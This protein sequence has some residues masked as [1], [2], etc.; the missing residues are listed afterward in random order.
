MLKN[1]SP[2]PRTTF[3]KW[4]LFAGLTLLAAAMYWGFSN[5]SIPLSKG[6]F[7]SYLTPSIHN[8]LLPTTITVPWDKKQE[9]FKTYL[10]DYTIDLEAQ[11]IATKLLKA[12]RSDYGALV[13]IDA[14]T[15]KILT[16]VSHYGPDATHTQYGNLALKALF[17]SASVFKVITAAAAIETQSLTPDSVI[18]FN[19][20]SHTLY[21]KNV[22]KTD[23]NRWTR[24]MT[25]K[26]AFGKSVNTVFGKLG[27]LYIGP[28][29]LQ[30]YAEKFQFNRE[31]ASDFDFESG[32][33]SIDQ[34]D[35][36]QNAEI[37]SGFTSESTLSPLHGAL[38]AATIVNDG[39]MMEPFL[40]SEIRDQ[41]SAE[42]VFQGNAKPLEQS[43][44]LSSATDLQSLMKETVQKG[45]SRKS[46]Q[47]VFN[48]RLPEK[49]EFGGKTGT[50]DNRNEP[51]G[52]AD[53]FVG[54]ADTGE[55][56]IAIAVL[57]LHEKYWRVKSS[58]LAGEFFKKVFGIEKIGKSSAQQKNLQ[59][60]IVNVEA[61]TKNSSTPLR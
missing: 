45:T 17:P 21:K 46:F 13:A 19:G 10:V 43:L 11:E 44:T 28:K 51:R 26:E 56:K 30:E 61:A 59:K 41:E 57:T 48:R 47:K 55:E 18:P 54:Y 31:I 52:R 20:A 25:L 50:L 4:S 49:I 2:K 22:K 38:I 3:K 12:N 27:A 23:Y 14:K 35:T 33:T 6:Y 37:A 36:Y 39:L 40:I 15:G 53:W 32:Q 1:I 60:K 58:Y 5:R 7:S 8:G 16:L 34:N 42:I 9:T 29:S 24:Y